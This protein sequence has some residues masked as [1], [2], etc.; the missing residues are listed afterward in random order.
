MITHGWEEEV[1]KIGSLYHLRDHHFSS[2]K[3]KVL[4]TLGNLCIHGWEYERQRSKENPLTPCETTA[5]PRFYLESS[6]LSQD[7]LSELLPS[8]FNPKELDFAAD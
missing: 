6:K 5:R 8:L 2:S 3:D 1:F 7:L 4:N